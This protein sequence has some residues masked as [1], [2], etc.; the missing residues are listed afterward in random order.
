MAL[1]ASNIKSLTNKK[2]IEY[3]LGL[4]KSAIDEYGHPKQFMVF[5]I[6]KDTKSSK[7]AGDTGSDNVYIAADSGGTGV[8]GQAI[9]EKGLDPNFTTL[10][11]NVD[12]KT[13]NTVKGKEELDRVVILPMPN[14]HNVNTSVDYDNSFI[15]STLTKAADMANQNGGALISEAARYG[16]T[17]A[18]GGAINAIKSGIFG[19]KDVTDTT[20]LLAA[21]G[22]AINPKKEVMFRG[23]SFRQFT[24]SYFFAPKNK[25]ESDSVNDI[26]RTFRYYALPE[27][28][29]AK[30]FYMFPAQFDVEFMY[31]QELNPNI[32]R[33]ARS[34]LGRV[35]VNYS[36]AGTSW[37]TLPNGSPVAIQMTLEFIETEL[38]DRNRVSNE[39]S[40]FT[41]GF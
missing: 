22:L 14:D 4:A 31:G 41:S 9:N 5:K 26:I 23:F 24:F 36:P 16:A 12:P 38:I 21:Q 37:V 28:S 25:A 15:P 2:L 8:S 7:L 11:G 20:S 33:I 29:P 3:P 17:A 39:T 40:K 32:P 13:I 19:G 18:F 1:P 27:I 10:Y 35:G 34:V 6:I 30:L